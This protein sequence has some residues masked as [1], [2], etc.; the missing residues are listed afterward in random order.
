MKTFTNSV[1]ADEVATNGLLNSADLNKVIT[2]TSNQTLPGNYRFHN[3][4]ITES[5]EV[6]IRLIIKKKVVM[7]ILKI[8]DRGFNNRFS[9]KWVR[10]DI[11]TAPVRL[12][13][14]RCEF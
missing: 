8:L 4:E 2:L 3:L 11:D 6:R 14:V 1:V 12:Y 10:T 13:K 9:C 7:Y 5:L